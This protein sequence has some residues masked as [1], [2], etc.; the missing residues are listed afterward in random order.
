MLA[1]KDYL[2]K[3]TLGHSEDLKI[4]LKSF[5]F[6]SVNWLVKPFEAS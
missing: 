2:Y 3:G 6:K 4:K 5:N 1:N